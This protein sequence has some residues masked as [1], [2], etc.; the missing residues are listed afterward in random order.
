ME[1]DIRKT[2]AKC[3]KCKSLDIIIYEKSVHLQTWDQINGYVDYNEGNMNPGGVIGTFGKCNC[4]H[5]W[6]FKCL[7]I[8]SLFI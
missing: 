1:Q 6:K 5:A 3:P 7:Q 4:G 8:T 2:K